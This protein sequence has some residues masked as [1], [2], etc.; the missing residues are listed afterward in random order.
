M[1]VQLKSQGSHESACSSSLNGSEEPYTSIRLVFEWIRGAPQAHAPIAL[2]VC[3]S[4]LNGSQ[5]PHISMH[6]SLYYSTM[7]LIVG[8][9]R[10]ALYQQC[11]DCHHINGSGSYTSGLAGSVKWPGRAMLRAINAGRR[12]GEGGGGIRGRCLCIR[13]CP[14][15]E[16]AR[17]VVQQHVRI[18]HGFSRCQRTTRSSNQSVKRGGWRSAQ[19]LGRV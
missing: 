12:K 19:S 1:P 17:D 13:T 10:I 3:W 11:A 18:E 2:D 8:W 16:R 4:S 5:E 9:V 15:S 7:Q 6:Q 14:C